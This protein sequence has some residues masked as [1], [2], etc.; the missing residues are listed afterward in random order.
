MGAINQTATYTE[1]VKATLRVRLANGREWD[2]TDE[3]LRKFGLDSRLDCYMR[4]D[5]ALRKTL[6]DAGLLGTRGD[7]TDAALNAV[8]Y[9]AEI[10]IGHPDL[11][12]H[13]EH[14]GWK[15]VVAIEKTLQQ[16]WGGT[17][18]PEDAAVAPETAPQE[19]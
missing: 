3:D 15:D 7:I 13:P 19:A 2:A 11:L 14:E 6:H 16:A 12:N 18:P 10:A 1:P 8:R 4:F 5:D 9:L 17:E